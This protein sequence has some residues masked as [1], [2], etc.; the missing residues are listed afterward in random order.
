[1]TGAVFRGGFSRLESPNK[2]TDV[3]RRE[4][5]KCKACGHQYKVT[6]INGLFSRLCSSC[7]YSTLWKRY[8][9]N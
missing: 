7:E 6:T 5:M 3:F 1:M 2:K 8:K 9:A 4:K